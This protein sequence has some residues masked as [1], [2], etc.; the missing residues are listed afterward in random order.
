[1]VGQ[2]RDE[3]YI[4]QKIVFF[5]KLISVISDFL[6]FWAVAPEGRCPVEYRGYF[7]IRPSVRLYPPPALRPGTPGQGP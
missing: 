3:L 7:S 5:S 6:G 1:M 4:F 2:T